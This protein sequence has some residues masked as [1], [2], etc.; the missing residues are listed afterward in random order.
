MNIA[1]GNTKVDRIGIRLD[2]ARERSAT[3]RKLARAAEEDESGLETLYKMAVDED[4]DNRIGAF[5]KEV[6]NE[7]S[8]LT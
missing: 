8:R 7:P 1:K 2:A 3:Y 4:R 6:R 5:D